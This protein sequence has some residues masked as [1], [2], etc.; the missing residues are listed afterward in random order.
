MKRQIPASHIEKTSPS[1]LSARIRL[2]SI[3]LFV[4]TQISV[5]AQIMYQNVSNKN[6]SLGSYGRVGVD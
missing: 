6:I 2:F 5:R 1:H 3:V 4:L